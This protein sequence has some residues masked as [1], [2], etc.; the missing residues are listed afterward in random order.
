MGNLMVDQCPLCDRIKE[1]ASEF[2]SFHNAASA[3]LENAYPAWNKAFGGALTRKE[4]FA[5]LT[6]MNEAGQAV[7]DLI[8]HLQGKGAV[9]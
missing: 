7:K 8:Q 4:Y 1:P 9:G 5:K 6:A 3:N 2:C